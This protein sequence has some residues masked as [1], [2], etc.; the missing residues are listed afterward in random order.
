MDVLPGFLLFGVSLAAIA[1]ITERDG[2]W[3]WARLLGTLGSGPIVIAGLSLAMPGTAINI[4]TA[5]VA[6]LVPVIILA[7]ALSRQSSAQVAAENGSGE[8]RGV[9]A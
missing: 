4:E 1:A 9:R 8:R 3:W 6:F 2:K 5:A 7:V